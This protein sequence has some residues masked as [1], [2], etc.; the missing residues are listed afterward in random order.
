[1]SKKN[2]HPNVLFIMVDEFRFP[3]IYTT[4]EVREWSE[5]ELKAINWLSKHGVEFKHHY[6]GSTACSPSRAT[7]FTGQYPSLHGVSQ[8]DGA[9]KTAYDPDIFW[10]DPQTVPTLGEYLEVAGYQT[11]YKGKWHISEADILIPTTHNPLPS[12]NPDTGVPD[13]KTEE[14][15]LAGDRLDKFGFHSW[16]GPEPHGSNPHNSG[17]SSAIGLPGR[18]IVYAEEVKKLIADLDT[19]KSDKPW[20]MVAS[21]VNPHDI[22]MFGQLAEVLPQY[23]FEPDKSVPHD[24]P[25]APTADENLSTK[26]IAQQSY[27]EVYPQALQPTL[28]S[29]HYRRL[30]YSL[31]LEADRRVKEVLKA[32]VRSRFKDNTLVVFTS[33]HGSLVGAHGGLFQKWHN[34]YEETIHVPLIFWGPNILAGQEGT[35]REL[36]TNHVDL[37]PTILG[38]VGVDADKVQH[39]LKSSHS[40]VHPFVGR[41]LAPVVRSSK[42]EIERSFD[43]PVYFMTDDKFSKGLNQVTL[44]GQPYHAVIEPN[45]VQTVIATIDNR[46]YKFSQYFDNIAFS[47]ATS[48]S[49]PPTAREQLQASLVPAQYEMYNLDD[50]PLETRNLADPAFS[51]EHTRQIQEKLYKLLL[52]ECKHKRLSP[53]YGPVPNDRYCCQCGPLPAKVIAEANILP[54]N[55]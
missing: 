34:A 50:D 19:S 47:Q 43:S 55:P 18:D 41:N 17:S 15:Y 21:F 14:Y 46:L 28:D 44:F 7:I 42:R 9:A 16:I 48:T 27:R 13:P 6:V 2:S 26:P 35:T 54:R 32:L 30:Y 36:V 4:K 45:S 53:T 1:M 37:I 33:D 25:P 5:R 49:A 51:T 31:Q 12:Y 24:I 52:K 38:L 39:A 3:P 29:L 8:T 11:Y 40:E 22:A 20:F 10:L 23:N